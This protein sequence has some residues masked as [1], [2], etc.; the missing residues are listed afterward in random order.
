MSK[1]PNFTDDFDLS[2][3]RKDSP[4]RAAARNAVKE[5]KRVRIEQHRGQVNASRND[6]E[7]S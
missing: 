7:D 1:K 4:R 3:K 2:A 6:Y 5:I